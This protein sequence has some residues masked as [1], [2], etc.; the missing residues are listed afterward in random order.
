N[1]PADKAAAKRVQ[2]LLAGIPQSTGNVLG[3]ASAPVTVTEFGDLECSVCDEFDLPAGVTSPAGVPGTGILPTIIQQD[4]ATGKVKLV[5]KS[6]E[7]ASAD[8]A[9]AKMWT[10]QQAAA[11]AAGLQGKGW[12]YVELFYNEQGAEDTPYVTMSYLEGLAKQIPGLNYSKWLHDLNSDQAI[13]NQVASDN[14]EGAQLDLG[15]AS[16]P[17]IWIQ[18]PKNDAQFA[19]IT[20]KTVASELSVIQKAINSAA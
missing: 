14:T 4:V 9:N 3:K 8:P 7:T 1:S 17:T 6:L 15:K 16:T 10:T 13:R 11:N 12:N 19:G 2:S 20:E 18:G 5:Y